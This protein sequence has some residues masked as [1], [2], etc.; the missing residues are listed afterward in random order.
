MKK[1]LH[2]ILRKSEGYTKTDMVYLAKGGFWLNLGKGSSYVI[3]LILLYFFGNFLSQESYGTYQYVLSV[4]AALSFLSLK[5]MRTSLVKAIIKKKEGTLQAAV[6]EQLKFSLLGTAI[7]SGFAIFQ[8]MEGE[9][10]LFFLFLIA[11]V[12]FPFYNSFSIFI[13][14]WK[15]RKDFR[16]VTKYS[17][18]Y[19]T[20]SALFLIPVI[21]LTDELIMIVLVYFAANS[22]FRGISFLIARNSTINREVDESSLHYGKH[23]TAMQSISGIASHIDKVILWGFLGPLEVAIYSFAQKPLTKASGL[24]PVEALALPKLNERD[25]SKIKRKLLQKIGKFFLFIIPLVILL[26]LLAPHLYQI[27][28]PRYEE[29]VIYFQVMSLSLLLIPLKV[30]SSS[31][32]AKE[33]KKGLYVSY[34]ASPLLKIVLF[35]VLVPFYG[36]W[37]VVIGY[38]TEKLIHNGIN[39][40][41]FLRL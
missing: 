36:I 7:M 6:K 13:S 37:G 19:Q 4:A 35:L 12:F 41:Y 38:L 21:Y 26:I 17:L 32:K 5:G 20:L 28:L 40:Y 39:L 30:V 22:I 9:T 23:L 24:F 14:F 2:K 16:N 8:Y 1:I 31:L 15:G 25:I 18:L 29:S 34:I 33:E 3:S 10:N 11:A 27:L